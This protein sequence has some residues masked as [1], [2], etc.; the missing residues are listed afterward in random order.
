[1]I[2]IFLLISQI[3]IDNLI[4]QLGNDSYEI[5]EE[6]KI[7]LKKLEFKAIDK[8]KENFKN[9][10][11]EISLSCRYLY[12]DYF[13]VTDKDGKVP[14]IWYLDNKIRFPLGHNAVVDKKKNVCILKFKK[15][16]SLEYVNK[17]RSEINFMIDHEYYCTEE[18]CNCFCCC[19]YCYYRS[20]KVGIIAMKKYIED[21]LSSGKDRKALKKIIQKASDNSENYDLIH[22]VE[23]LDNEFWESYNN[24]PGIMIQK[25]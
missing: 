25:K 23:N 5:R 16:I 6:A 11:I 2:L 8:L 13:Y 17:I 10:D 4:N 21:W 1:M 9:K 15:D 12:S 3:S 18:C 7:K 19:D 22:T 20:K 14:S 24:P